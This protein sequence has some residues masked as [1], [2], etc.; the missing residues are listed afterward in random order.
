[1]IQG[2][3]WFDAVQLLT[4]N[5]NLTST[6]RVQLRKVPIQAPDGT[7]IKYE[8]DYHRT[9][10]KVRFLVCASPLLQFHA[11]SAGEGSPHL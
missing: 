7:E 4:S 3:A 8:P 1:M 9:Y 5:E 11:V 10:G 2:S 6:G